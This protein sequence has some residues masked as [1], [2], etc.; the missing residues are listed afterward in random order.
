MYFI[1]SIRVL[2]CK[3]LI[4]CL[5]FEQTRIT[6]YAPKE[7]HVCSLPFNKHVEMSCWRW[8]IPQQIFYSTSEIGG[9]SHGRWTGRIWPRVNGFILFSVPSPLIFSSPCNNATKLSLNIL[10]HGHLKKL[11]IVA[12]NWEYLGSSLGIQH[13]LY[14]LLGHG[15]HPSGGPDGT[16]ANELACGR[17]GNPFQLKNSMCRL[18]TSPNLAALNCIDSVLSPRVLSLPVTHRDFGGIDS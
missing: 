8:K 11:P 17:K 6:V 1:V 13:V 5:C 4:G 14:A 10:K 3:S 15:S 2:Q 9:R 12:F 18:F 16:W 7:S